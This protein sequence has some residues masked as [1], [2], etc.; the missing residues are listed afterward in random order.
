MGRMSRNKGARGE[1]ELSKELIRL[2][3]VEAHRGR[4]YH[5]GPGTP[6][7]MADIPG[8]H[9]EVKRT[10]NLSLYKAMEQAAADV[11]DVEDI[12]VVAHRRNR[13]PWVVC[14][15]LDDLPKLAM[16]IYLTMQENN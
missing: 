12:P 5:G 15:R 11:F 7:V 4:Q 10:E 8:V 1:R 9:W 14:C 3:G 13:R 16:R 6:D 2:F